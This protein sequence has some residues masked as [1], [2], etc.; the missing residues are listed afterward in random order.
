MEENEILLRVDNLS[1]KYCHSFKR[2]LAY[3][4]RDIAA[5]IIGFRG[6]DPQHGSGLNSRA[7]SHNAVELRRDEFWA[8][9][10]VSFELRRGECLG[11]IGP[12][13]AG[14]SSL[15]RMLNGLI[16]PD[17]GTITIRGRVGGIIEFEP[18]FLPILTGR[19]NVYI[20]GS[21]IGL[22]KK[23]IEDRFDEIVRFAELEEFIDMP[24][25]YYSSGMKV[26]LGFSVALQLKPDVLIID[27]VLAVGDNEFRTKCLE[28]INRLLNHSAVILVS[29]SMSMIAK[30]STNLLV[31]KNGEIVYKSDDV[32]EGIRRYDS[33][34]I[35]AETGFTQMR[36]IAFL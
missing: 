21:I 17:S 23:E 34:F 22:T 14:K 27:E 7:S 13:G 35:S 16:K 18:G 29:H 1:K 3:G 36:P 11:L 26:R 31:L 9:R 32:I 6:I 10:D 12:N 19:E 28:A 4:L 2:S 30:M 20:S 33:N 24:V 15:L 25:Q 8:L 5:E